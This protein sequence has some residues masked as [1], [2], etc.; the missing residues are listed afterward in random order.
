MQNK[1]RQV[2]EAKVKDSLLRMLLLSQQGVWMTPIP[3]DL[4]KGARRQT[5]KG[6]DASAAKARGLF[7]KWQKGLNNPDTGQVF[8]VLT[9]KQ[10]LFPECPTLRWQGG[11]SVKEGVFFIIDLVLLLGS[12]NLV[13]KLS[14]ISPSSLLFLGLSTKVL[15]NPIFMGKV[16]EPWPWSN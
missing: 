10:K 7:H 14:I 13:R 11:I 3:C 4:S 6:L 5:R 15:F 16:G 2:N 12:Q 1:K 9:H 8:K